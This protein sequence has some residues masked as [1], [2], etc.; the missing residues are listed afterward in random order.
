MNQIRDRVIRESVQSFIDNWKTCKHVLNSRGYASSTM[1]TYHL[2][3]RM[4]VGDRQSIDEIH[5]SG[6]VDKVNLNKIVELQRNDDLTF[7]AMHYPVMSDFKAFYYKKRDRQIRN[8]IVEHYGSD[9]G[10]SSIDHMVDMLDD[11]KAYV[12]A[13]NPLYEKICDELEVLEA[14][15]D[16]MDVSDDSSYRIN[17]QIN[18]HMNA[19]KA[20]L[21]RA[22]RNMLAED[23]FA[24]ERTRI[25]QLEDLGN[26]VTMITTL[27]LNISE[28]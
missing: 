10:M 19:M 22:K 23:Y 1:E 7:V 9:E 13:S 3:K 14:V 6:K 5:S 11:I 25:K 28:N 15:Q 2:A 26:R 16:F 17:Q 21:Q 20:E 18:S 24:L 27:M 12:P 8:L 4:L